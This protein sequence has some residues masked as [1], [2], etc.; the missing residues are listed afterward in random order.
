MAHFQDSVAVA[1]E[2][3]RRPAARDLHRDVVGYGLGK[4][5]EVTAAIALPRASVRATFVFRR[6]KT[7]ATT[8]TA[9]KQT[10]KTVVRLTW[11]RRGR[12]SGVAMA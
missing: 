11:D 9:P 4:A 7:K 8:D 2:G 3:L 10:V 1:F 5:K 6:K 12:G